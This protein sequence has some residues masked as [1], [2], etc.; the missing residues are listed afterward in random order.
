[1]HRRTG[2]E[3]RVAGPETL[4]RGRRSALERAVGNLVENAAKFDAGGEEPVQ[5]RVG[6]DG[7]SVADRGPGIAEPDRDRVFDRF[8]RADSARA[9]PGSGLG[10]S[11]VRDVAL[12]HGGRAFARPREGGGAV[13]GFTLDAARLLLR[14]ESC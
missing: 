5:V 9:L 7:V 10:L 4:V 2:R 3:I 8:Y 6:P 14:S 11:I 13:V 1:M 12:T